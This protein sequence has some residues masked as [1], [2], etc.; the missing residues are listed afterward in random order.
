MKDQD[1]ETEGNAFGI[2]FLLPYHKIRGQ[3]RGRIDIITKKI[4]CPEPLI[5]R[6]FPGI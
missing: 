4:R 2:P 1:I 3:N 5:L 6:Y